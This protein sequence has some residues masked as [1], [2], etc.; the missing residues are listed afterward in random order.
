[1]W[2]GP[3]APARFLSFELDR[4][5]GCTWESLCGG[6][7]KEGAGRFKQLWGGTKR[8]HDEMVCA[9]QYRGMPDTELGRLGTPCAWWQGLR[10]LATDSVLPPAMLNALSHASREVAGWADGYS[11]TEREKG[12]TR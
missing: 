12:V 4:M 5:L 8:L 10:P 11:M 2:R 7:F 9:G 3:S 6:R 1:M